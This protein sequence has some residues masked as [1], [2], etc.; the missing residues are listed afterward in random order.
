M[1]KQIYYIKQYIF[2]KCYI[3]NKKF[4]IKNYNKKFKYIIKI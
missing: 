4:I 2:L 1:L 3:Y